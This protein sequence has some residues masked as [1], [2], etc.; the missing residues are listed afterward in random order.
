MPQL[1]T[2]SATLLRQTR[3]PT[4]RRYGGRFPV[5]TLAGFTSVRWPTS[6]RNGGRLRVGIP[7]RL[8]LEFASWSP[9]PGVETGFSML[10][11]FN[12]VSGSLAN[13]SKQDNRRLADTSPFSSSARIGYRCAL[14]DGSEIGL[15]ADARYV[16]RSI[17]G[18]GDY[19]DIP[20]GKYATLDAAIT[21]SGRDR[22]ISLT[23]EN[24]GNSASNRFSFGNP[25][26]LSAR[27]QETPLRP[28]TVSLSVG[29]RW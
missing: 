24:L 14:A 8:Q 4:S 1:L 23:I 28:L 16:G 3:W 22:Q 25:F 12:S 21:W 20:Q 29:K 15:L 7:G 9:L 11:S 2:R 19:F 13:L 5:G 6:A 26:L 18:T 10:Y 17:L 27:N